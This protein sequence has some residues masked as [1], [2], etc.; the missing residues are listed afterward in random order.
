MVSL[1]WVP[2]QGPLLYFSPYFNENTH[3]ADWQPCLQW[4]SG[5]VPLFSFTCCINLLHIPL[6]SEFH[7]DFTCSTQR[8]FGCK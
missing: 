6:H 4:F 8:A 7:L 5:R 1:A 2:I 3:A